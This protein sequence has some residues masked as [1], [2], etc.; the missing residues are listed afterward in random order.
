M[1]AIIV[2]NIRRGGCPCH[3][4]PA[5]GIFTHHN[6]TFIP[7]VLL[8]FLEGPSHRPFCFLQ[9]LSFEGGSRR[10]TSRGGGCPCC[11]S[12][13]MTFPAVTQQSALFYRSHSCCPWRYS[14]WPR[15]QPLNIA[16]SYWQDDASQRGYLGRQPGRR[17]HAVT[18]QRDNDKAP[19]S[20]VGTVGSGSGM[21]ASI[22][23]QGWIFLNYGISNVHI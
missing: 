20:V 13:H 23:R 11:Q 7:L 3:Q 14:S 16:T 2:H 19:L 21:T 5:M 17:Q 6:L 8:G 4:V 12:R 1:T 9:S 18:V 15:W 10:H 22:F